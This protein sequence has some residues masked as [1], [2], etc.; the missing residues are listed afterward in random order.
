[1]REAEAHRSIVNKRMTCDKI[2]NKRTDV[3]DRQNAPEFFTNI[4]ASLQ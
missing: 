4:S 1:M 3:F 2:T